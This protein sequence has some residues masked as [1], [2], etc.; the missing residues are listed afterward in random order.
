MTNEESSKEIEK[1]KEQES[2]ESEGI[3]T[4]VTPLQSNQ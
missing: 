4:F 1:N 3:P 2:S